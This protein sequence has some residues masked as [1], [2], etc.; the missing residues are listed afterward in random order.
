MKIQINLFNLKTKQ[1]SVQ[2]TDKSIYLCIE[3]KL[4]YLL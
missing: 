4:S 2:T 3:L 1:D